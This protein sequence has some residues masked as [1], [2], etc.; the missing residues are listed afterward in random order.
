MKQKRKSQ[1]S[2]SLK[3]TQINDNPSYNS[4]ME[5]INN[6]K[7]LLI[8]LDTNE[9]PPSKYFA[10]FISVTDELA[11]IK[12]KIIQVKNQHKVSY[13]NIFEI[14]FTIRNNLIK[15]Y[16]LS[17][18]GNLICTEEINKVVPLINELINQLKVID[19]P[20]VSFFA[21]YFCFNCFENTLKQCDP[22]IAMQYYLTIISEMSKLL[23]KMREEVNVQDK[24]SKDLQNLHCLVIENINKLISLPNKESFRNTILPKIISLVYDEETKLYSD[25]ILDWFISGLNVDDLVNN[26]IIIIGILEKVVDYEQNM[27]KKLNNMIEKI[28]SIYKG[29]KQAVQESIINL[30]GGG[31]FKNIFETIVKIMKKSKDLKTIEIKTYLE[32][33]SSLIQFTILL[34]KQDDTNGYFNIIFGILDAYLKD[35]KKEKTDIGLNNSKSKITNSSKDKEKKKHNSILDD[36]H[37]KIYEKIYRLLMKAKISIFE[38]KNILSITDYFNKEYKQKANYNLL[39][40][41]NCLN[42]ILD[43]E[44]KVKFLV[45]IAKNALNINVN[46]NYKKEHEQN[47]LCTITER[48]QN[49]DPEKNF[50]LLIIIKNIFDKIST[51]IFVEPLVENY[52]YSFIRLAKNVEKCYIFYL[53]KKENPDFDMEKKDFY[54]MDLSSYTPSKYVAYT[55]NLYLLIRESIRADFSSYPKA[56]LQF[57]LKAI[58]HLEQLKYE[59]AKYSD[60]SYDYFSVFFVT[61]REELLSS[62][63]KADYTSKIITVLSNTTILTK[64]KYIKITNKILEQ[65]KRLQKRCET[66]KI[67]LMACDLFYNNNYKNIDMINKN[68]YAAEK[69]AEFS[70]VKPENLNLFVLLLE[71]LIFYYEKEEKFVT[72]SK[73]RGTEK[74]IMDHIEDVK[75]VDEKLADTMVVQMKRF[76]EKIKHLESISVLSLEEKVITNGDQNEKDE[77]KKEKEKT[78]EKKE[79]REEKKEEETQESKKE[80][81]E[82][83]QS[84]EKEENDK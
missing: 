82:N 37:F 75:K 65:S 73:I 63:D 57:L 43:N 77:G 60:V 35:I 76:G 11:K 30:I 7:S 64:E 51:K 54:D 44:D 5:I 68:L 45:K 4:I 3:K 71:K 26:F 23:N 6:S 55:K 21:C 84:E 20:I 1:S 29:G 16:L 8:T 66:S 61:L 49:R 83:K 70:M 50:R 32:H 38:M 41:L 56:I 40:Y 59:K 31:N 58:D 34:T 79:E 10:N 52:L 74:Y 47:I 67:M 2:F 46:E 33:I 22:E 53:E 80:E 48:I 14:F 36:D 81:K 39:V 28:L 17:I 78:E 18:V 25:Y 72:I 13:R 27:L 42:E 69:D 62:S 24:F 9:K 19:Y 15:T 12:E